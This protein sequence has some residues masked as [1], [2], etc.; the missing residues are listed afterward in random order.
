[1]LTPIAKADW[2]QFRGENVDGIATTSSIL[3][4]TDDVQLQVA[5]KRPLGS[6]YS[7][8]VTAGDR[9]VTAYCDDQFGYVICLSKTDGKTFWRY[10]T[11]AKNVGENGSFDGPIATPAIGFGKTFMVTPAGDF[12]AINLESGDLAW[13]V[14]LAEQLGAAPIFYGFGASPTI[15]GDHVV[16]EVGTPKGALC[17]FDPLSGKIVWEAGDDSSGYQN[18]VP[19]QLGN[20]NALIAAGNSKLLGVNAD[21]GDVLFEFAHEGQGGRGAWSLIPVPMGKQQLFLAHDDTRSQMVSIVKPA[22]SDVA[23]V[24]TVWEERSIRNSYNVPVA[25]DDH[26]YAFS[27]RILSC[28]DSDGKLLWRSRKP[29]DGFLSIVDGHLV[30]VTKKGTVHLSPATTSG[31]EELAQVD[32]FENTTWSIP[33][34]DGNSIF[35][36]S[37]KEIARVDVV[38]GKV[39]ET[40]LIASVAVGP[41][42]QSFLDSVRSSANKQAEVDRFMA[43]LKS[44]P[45]IEGDT[46]HF[47]LQGKY[48]DVAVAG[49]L[50]GVRQE[51]AMLRVPGTDLFYFAARTSPDTRASYVF[52]ADYQTIPD[53]ANS[54]TTRSSFLVEDIEMNILVGGELLTMSWFDMPQHRSVLSP[55]SADRPGA[56]ELAGRLQTDR[57]TSQAMNGEEI[58]VTTYLPPGHSN[59][60]NR[61]PVAFIHGGKEALQNGRLH[62]V[63]DRMIQQGNLPPS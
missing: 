6:G 1:M 46:V 22:E 28:A 27:S 38:A 39:N 37:I 20:T 52:I 53:P 45:H 58:S 18:A 57:L 26:L 54:R 49:D 32:V 30:V 47:L 55:A 50:F 60:G 29:G 25:Y 10:K 24:E 3:S 59:L 40:E 31:Y 56:T 14:N 34:V 7:S 42:F 43:S 63:A 61:Y 17:A 35:V 23:S 48:N 5:W 33:A 13:K 15:H 62:E 44:T 8:V 19:M 9:L 2:P 21:S 41:K 16:L 36:R 12:L 51:R 11:G 4:Q